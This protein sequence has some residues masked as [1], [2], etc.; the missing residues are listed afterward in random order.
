MPQE[1]EVFYILPAIRRDFS[2]IM[3]KKGFTQRE[4]SKKLNITEAAVS[5][6]ISKKRASEVKFNDTIKKEINRSVDRFL[7]KGDLIEEMQFVCNKV[8]SNLILCKIHQCKNNIPKNCRAC[9]K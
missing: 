8:K 3:I 5:Q 2:K 7:N 1:I 4:I 9:L 6:Y